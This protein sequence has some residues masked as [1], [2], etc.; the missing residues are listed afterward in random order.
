MLTQAQLVSLYRSLAGARVLTVY[1]AGANHDPALRNGWR[2]DLDHAIK[3]LHTWLEGS[4]RVERLELDRC[5]DLLETELAAFSGGLGSP[6]WVAFI[7]PEGVREA[8]ALP[9]PVPTVA[10]WNTGACVAPYVEVLRELDDVVVVV[11][12]AREAMVYRYHNAALERVETIRAHHVIERSLH[13]GASARVGFHTGTRGSTGRDSAQRSLLTG[14]DRMLDETVERTAALANGN[15]WIVVGGVPR[16][17][18]YLARALEPFARLRVVREPAIGMNSAEAEI[19]AA[20]RRGAGVLR[21]AADTRRI[22]ELLNNAS[23]GGLA[24][25]G[26]DAAERALNS[27]AVHALLLTRRFVEDNAAEAEDA[28]RAAF[29]QNAAVDVIAGGAEAL[30]EHGGIAAELR[31]SLFREPAFAADSRDAPEA[32]PSIAV[33]DLGRS[34]NGAVIPREAHAFGPSTE[35]VPWN[36]SAFARRSLVTASH[37]PWWRRDSP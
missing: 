6:G 11:A 9:A 4:T 33:L 19:T 21:T 5:L 8:H 27:A 36:A 12:D 35:P 23:T 25:L 22:T 34:A 18:G 2:V 3:D 7:T 26:P 28:V 30:D 24:V 16:I 37:S 29:D 31:F 1:L 15:G 17:S 32:E 20:A 10:L 14:R 13:M